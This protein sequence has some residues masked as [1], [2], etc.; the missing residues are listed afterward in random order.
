MLRNNEKRKQQ[1]RH[2]HVYNEKVDV[3]SHGFRLVDNSDDDSDDD[4]PN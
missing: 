3:F 4:V 1:I 2:G